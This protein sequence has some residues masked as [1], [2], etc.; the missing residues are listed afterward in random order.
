VIPDLLS[1]LDEVD[2]ISKTKVARIITCPDCGKLHK[3]RCDECGSTRDL[4]SY[5]GPCG[6]CAFGDKVK[7]AHVGNVKTAFDMGQAA[8][9]AQAFGSRATR[10]VRNQAEGV[11]KNLG[12]ATAAW[13]SPKK[14]FQK[15]WESTWRPGGQPLSLPWKALMGYGLLTGT[16]DV[17][18]RE[19]PSGQG[20]SRVRRA[21]R[22]AG[23]Q[24]GGI[25]GAPFGFTGGLL[26][27][28]VGSK[29][30]DTAGAAVDKLRGVRPKP[31]HPP[32]LPPPPQGLRD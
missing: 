26:S 21:L 16:R 19:D 18:K 10:F 31:A 3:P 5:H 32:S 29:I 14:S 4:R 23:D 7:K 15:G 22:F 20:H 2:Q 1:F 25:I 11:G 8:G 30:G 13:A 12:K 28:M 27:S 24:A 17:L 6:K 9:Q